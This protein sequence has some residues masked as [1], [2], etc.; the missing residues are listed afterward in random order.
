ML[1]LS[2]QALIGVSCTCMQD[3]V[4][5]QLVLRFPISDALAADNDQAASHQFET[6]IEQFYADD[7]AAADRT[8]NMHECECVQL[9]LP[10]TGQMMQPGIARVMQRQPLT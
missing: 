3:A 4:V 5:H 9:T 7:L 10:V 1:G 8:C 6:A 2:G